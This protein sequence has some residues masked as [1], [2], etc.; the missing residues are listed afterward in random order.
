MSRIRSLLLALPLALLAC[1]DDGAV[2]TSRDTA[3][4]ASPAHAGERGGNKVLPVMTR[5]L[6][7]GA[8]LGPVI[9]AR[10]LDEFLDA[11]TAIWAMVQTNDFTTRAEA[12]ADEIAEQRPALVGL[13]EAYLWRIQS[14]GDAIA[15]GGMPA[16][17]TRYDYVADLLR[18]LAERGLV[19]RVAAEVAL[20][21][22][23][24]PVR[25]DGG[26]DDVRMTDRGV[27][28]AHEDVHTEQR[29]E[30]VF[31][32]ATLLPLPVFGRREPV[33][34]RRG[35]VS[36]R[37]KYR[38]E[39]LRFVSTHLEAFQPAPRLAQAAVL[40]GAL[41][42]EEL[43]VV[44][45]GDL[46]STPGT[47]G[48]QV[49]ALAGFEDAWAALHPAE[50][51]GLTCCFADDLT[52]ADDPLETRIDYVL[53]RGALEPRAAEVVGDEE[54]VNGLWP[55]DHAGV[56]ARLRLALPGRDGTGRHP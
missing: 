17:E 4:A 16:T 12:I 35:W 52:V 1:G 36:T 46:N 26:F 9:A 43:P 56:A 38:G 14:P 45:V 24:A 42:G 6:Y 29:E 7:L 44:L 27:I 19:Y 34:V 11:T 48:A 20:F 23:E 40:A 5:N 49:L 55:S 37:A 51:Q 53:F 31:P 54:L 22:F 39:W 25:A 21:D 18:A 13:Q 41:A 2:A 47:E 30:H 8:D 32:D 3:N 33:L 10:K 28:L 50:E 15:G